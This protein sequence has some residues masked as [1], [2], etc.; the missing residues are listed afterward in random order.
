[1]LKTDERTAKMVKTST[2]RDTEATEEET[3]VAIEAVTVKT[4]RKSRDV[5]TEDFEN[6][7]ANLE[8]A[9]V[10][11]APQETAHQENLD[12]ESE[13][14]SPMVIDRM[15][16]SGAGYSRNTVFSMFQTVKNQ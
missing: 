7:E 4:A 13:K 1:M 14:N 9:T 2:E 5:E 8:G 15:S 10:A 11:E 16:G 6:R 3:E 12:H